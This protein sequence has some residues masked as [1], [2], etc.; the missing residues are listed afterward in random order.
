M[1]RQRSLMAI[2]AAFA[3]TIASVVSAQE[4]KQ[5]AAAPAA[6]SITPTAVTQDMLDKAAGDSKNFLHTNGDYTQQR[7]YPNKQITPANVAR[8]R[9]AWIFQ[10]EVTESMETSPIV[11]NGV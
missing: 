2:S 6:A 10:T 1:T 8:L 4:V 5:N 3:L 7:Y 11:V 9:P